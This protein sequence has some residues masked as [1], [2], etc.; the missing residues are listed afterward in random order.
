MAV[1][2]GTKEMKSKVFCSHQ[3]LLNNDSIRMIK[4]IAI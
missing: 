3:N 1:F 4:L 2:A